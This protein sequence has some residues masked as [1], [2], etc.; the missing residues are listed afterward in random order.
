MCYNPSW[1]PVGD[2]KEVGREGCLSL[3]GRLFRVER[4]YEIEAQWTNAV[5]HHQ[6]KKL[7]GW[8]ARVFQHEAD[9]L[10]GIIL[11]DHADEV[12]EAV[13]EKK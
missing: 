11:S 1:K 10:K 9:H 3:P 13:I 5:G 6:K 8:A 12:T 2:K 7:R 4:Y